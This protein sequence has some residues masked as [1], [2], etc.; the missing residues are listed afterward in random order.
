[1]RMLSEILVRKRTY[2]FFGFRGFDI[3]DRYIFRF[4]YYYCAFGFSIFC[5][6]EEEGYKVRNK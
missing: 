3:D 2:F 4:I 1:M 6:K 5:S